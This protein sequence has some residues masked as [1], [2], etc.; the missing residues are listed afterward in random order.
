MRVYEL[1]SITCPRFLS[2][3]YSGWTI[4]T[5]GKKEKGRSPETRRVKRRRHKNEKRRG[6]KVDEF[7]VQDS[8]AEIR[9]RRKNPSIGSIRARESIHSILHLSIFYCVCW[10]LSIFYCVWNKGDERKARW[11]WTPLLLIERDNY[12]VSQSSRWIRQIERIVNKAGRRFLLPPSL[13]RPL[14]LTASLRNLSYLL[15]AFYCEMKEESRNESKTHS[16]EPPS[17]SCV[18]PLCSYCDLFLNDSFTR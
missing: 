7:T 12:E 2:L 14:G 15:I 9:G 11:N 3:S 10:N 13:I 17:V 16:L 5:Q 4:Q 8:I 6:V 18:R 1:N